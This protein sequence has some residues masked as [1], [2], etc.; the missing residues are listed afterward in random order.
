MGPAVQDSKKYTLQIPRLPTPA[1]RATV[2]VE[3]ATTVGRVQESA[4]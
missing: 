2:A 4:V 3:P 1:F